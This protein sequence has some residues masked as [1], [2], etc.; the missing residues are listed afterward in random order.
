[1]EGSWNH[2]CHKERSSP[3][4]PLDPSSTIDPLEQPADDEIFGTQR[5]Y[6]TESSTNLQKRRWR[7][8]FEDSLTEDRNIFDIFDE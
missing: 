5:T 4:D 2:W 8:V 7:W 3:Y 1:M 6:L